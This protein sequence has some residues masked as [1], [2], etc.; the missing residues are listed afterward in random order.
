MA[1]CKVVRGSK[2]NVARSGS[3]AVAADNATINT[4]NYPPADAINVSSRAKQITAFWNATGAAWPDAIQLQ[5]LHYE[6]AVGGWIE[7]EKATVSPREL[8]TFNINENSLVYL[9]VVGV[10][11]RGGATVTN[12][13][14][15]AAM[16]PVV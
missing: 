4:T 13:R 6:G 5:V 7:G 12:L 3:G 11:L 10:N 1:L 16:G 15:Y 9:R 2:Y 8:A 14:V